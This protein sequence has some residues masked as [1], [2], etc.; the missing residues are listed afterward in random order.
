MLNETFYRKWKLNTAALLT[1]CVDEMNGIV[2]DAAVEAGISEDMFYDP[3]HAIVWGA[4]IT[5]SRANE[6]VDLV[7]V[8]TA[9][10]GRM[11]LSDLN[12]LLTN[13]SAA[14]YSS[15]IKEIKECYRVHQLYRMSQMIQE[16]AEDF[17]SDELIANV[18]RVI[19]N[20]DS[21]EKSMLAA[22]D[23]IQM[24]YDYLTTQDQ[25]KKGIPTGFVRLD[26]TIRG[27]RKSKLIILA[28]RPSLGKSSLALNIADAVTAQTDVTT[29]IFS[30]EMK[31][32]ELGSRMIIARSEKAEDRIRLYGDKEAVIQP[33]RKAVEELKAR[34][35]FIDDSTDI[36]V[37]QIQ[38]RARKIK[39]R[40]GLGLVIVDY[41]QLV[42]PERDGSRQTR[43]QQVSGMSR[44]LKKMADNLD[45]PLICLAQLSRDSEKQG[46]KPRLSDLRES[47]A[48]EQDA[49][50]VLLL[51]Q[52][53]SMKE[54]DLVEAIVAK[55]RNGP[56]GE[57]EL[58]FAKHHTKF[59]DWKGDLNATQVELKP[60]PTEHPPPERRKYNVEVAP[61]NG[62]ML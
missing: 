43:E 46:R 31:A 9:V 50:V 5:L 25:E 15:Y 47:G 59:S 7:T 48:I 38:A 23:F 60:K 3:K 20:L 6:S 33:V 55:Q 28:A 54:I 37:H 8:S 17:D 40:H 36:T 39:N 32:E 30:L 26:E 49:D 2:L 56:T 58:K 35:I 12:N 10:S 52:D 27:L 29:A 21:T 44:A 4:I 57:V 41:L 34:K 61:Q 14:G 45:V 11:D 42:T 19:N 24:G 18:Q 22:P 16:E 51:H 1:V 13:G 62:G 53:E